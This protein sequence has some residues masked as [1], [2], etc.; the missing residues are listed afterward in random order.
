MIDYEDSDIIVRKILAKTADTRPKDSE[1]YRI[2]TGSRL[3]E[4]D[5]AKRVFKY[6]AKNLNPVTNDHWWEV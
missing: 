4:L 1:T 3:Y 2:G 5:G 6:S